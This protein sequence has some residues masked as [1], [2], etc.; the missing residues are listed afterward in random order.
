MNWVRGFRRRREQPDVLLAFVER[1]MAVVPAAYPVDSGCSCD[2]M[3]CPAPGT[4]PISYAWQGEASADPARLAH[5]RARLPE[6]NYVSPTGRTHDVLDVPAAAGWR[7]LNGEIAT[8][9]VAECG[10]RMLFFTL[11]RGRAMA[12]GAGDGSAADDQDGL[13]DDEWWPCELDCHPESAP[14]H[15]GLRWHNRGS[16]VVVPPSRLPSRRS[17]R[18]VRGP[19]LALPDPLLLLGPLTGACETV[20]APIDDALSAGWPSS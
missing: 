4:H 10:D 17:A 20:T 12:A 8:G 14:E 19:E 2:R 5:W 13:D 15:M 11:S 16:Y 18:W 3:G 7:V 6:A 9:P 1:G